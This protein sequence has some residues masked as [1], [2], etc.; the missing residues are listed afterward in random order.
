[1]YADD[2]SISLAAANVSDL[3]NEVN[4][5]LIRPGG[6]SSKLVRLKQDGAPKARVRQRGP[7]AS[8]PGK[9]LNLASLKCI[10]DA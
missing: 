4:R 6:S 1:M 7:G 2:T 5:E 3:E 8:S 10:L 9:F